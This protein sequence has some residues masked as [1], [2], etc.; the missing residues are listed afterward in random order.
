MLLCSDLNNEHEK[1]QKDEAARLT[2]DWFNE[3]LK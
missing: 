1:A 3:H 2:V